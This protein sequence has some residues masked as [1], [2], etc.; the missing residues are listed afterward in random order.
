[1]NVLDFMG[2]GVGKG[3]IGVTYR[4]DLETAQVSRIPLWIVRLRDF[5]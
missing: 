5:D 4:R 2:A 1:M 3:A